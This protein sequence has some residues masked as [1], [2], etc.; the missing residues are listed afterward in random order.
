MS[1]SGGFYDT[2]AE[3]FFEETAH[4]DMSSLRQCFTR[5]LPPRAAV[6]D[7]GCGSGRDARAFADEGFEVTAFDGSR[8]MVKRAIVETCGNCR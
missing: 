6:L 4:L 5:L 3:R 1:S 8:E 2:N 7:A